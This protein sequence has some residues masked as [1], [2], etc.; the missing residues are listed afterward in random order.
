M[1]RV[2]P[3]KTKVKVQFFK[4]FSMTDALVALCCIVVVG[5]ILLSGLAIKFILAIAVGLVCICL[6]VP[7][8]PETRIYQ[9]IGHFFRFIFANKTYT[10][11]DPKITKN[12]NLIT[13]FQGFIDFSYS[14][15]SES[16]DI[17]FIDYGD[18]CAS[19]IEVK[20]VQFYMLTEQR[21]NQFINAFDNA[22]KTLATDQIVSLVKT[23][24]RSNNGRNP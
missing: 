22:L 13:P 11:N 3:R 23:E 19:V 1:A 4:N 12:I 15:G 5:L 21:Q 17:S 10:K 14:D 6:F 16:D 8:S 9:S 7:L 18:Y 20:P 24:K 2:I